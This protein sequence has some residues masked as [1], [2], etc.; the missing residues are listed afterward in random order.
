[1]Q[2][3]K[4]IQKFSITNKVN[5]NF[6]N[7]FLYHS[8]GNLFYSKSLNLGIKK[9]LLF[10]CIICAAS[11]NVFS[12]NILNQPIDKDYSGYSFKQCFNELEGKY[13]IIFFYKS[14][15]I[16]KNEIPKIPKNTTLKTF[17][18]TAL[19]KYQL[20]YIQIQGSNIV[21][22]PNA[23]SSNEYANTESLIKQIGNPIDKGKYELN[24]VEGYVYFGKTSEPITGALIVDK[25]HN[26]QTITDY[27]GY[28][29][30][31]LPGGPTELQFSFIGLEKQVI[32]IDVFSHGKL[33]C[34]LMETPIA[35]GM[36]NIF[37]NSAKR[38][39]EQTQMGMAHVE[40]K[41]ISKLP[42]LMGETDIVKSMTL[43]PGIQSSGDLAA[44]FNVRGGNADQNLV[45]INGAT[46]FNTSHLFGM[47][48]TLIPNSINSVSMFK[49]TQTA[50]YGG[51]LSSVMDIGLTKPDTAKIEGKAGIGI[52][53][54]SLFVEGPIK[55]NFC[56]FMVG[57][58][59]T[60]SNWLL[61]TI[62]DIEIRNSQASFYDL[63]GKLDFKLNR[64]NRL[65]LFGYYSHDNFN[66]AQKNSYAYGTLIG[67]LNYRLYANSVLSIGVD[68]SHTDYKNSLG[69]IKDTK[70]AYMVSTGIAQTKLKIEFNLHLNKNSFV[71]GTDAGLYDINPGVKQ[72]YTDESLIIPDKVDN[73]KAI[74]SAAFAQDNITIT[75]KISLLLGLRY[76]WYSKYGSSQA[77]IYDPNSS[78]SDNSVTDTIN[79]GATELVN[80]YSGFEP[81]IGIKVKI[82]D[83]S[84]IKSGYHISRQYQH[85]IS[86]TSSPTPS[87][88]WKSTD[89]NIKPMVSHQLSL[90][91][92]RNFFEN[93]IETSAEAYYKTIS[94]TVDYRNGAVLVMNPNIERDVIAGFTQ[95]Y[96]LELM[97]KKNLGK[98]NGWLSYTI[99]R[100]QTKIDGRFP[101]D[102]INRGNYFPTYSDRLHDISLSVNYQFTRRWNFAG[103]FIFSS[104]RPTTYPE[105]KY[106]YR[107]VEVVY[108]SDRNKYRLPA[109]H[110]LDVSVTYEG[111]LKKTNKVHP[112]FTFSVY[113][114][115]GHK[116]TYSVY[117]K[118]DVPSSLNNYQK[119]GLYKLSIIGVPIPSVTVNLSF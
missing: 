52:L 96:G 13:S 88:Y 10:I 86:N 23:Y 87:D 111:F 75:N 57:G 59:T 41:S 46:L 28:Y 7:S 119:Y 103:N 54:S 106:E 49:G 81:R 17:I 67:G 80:P 38:N 94:N 6:M 44:G 22:I 85:L 91:Y 9:K 62:N 84:S 70:Q 115:Y 95:A 72:K 19:S 105:K 60:Y 112:S 43:L 104:G 117:Y 61:N 1:M 116:N 108:Y 12:Q 100:S 15:W 63:I 37:A 36:V 50:N 113:N 47:F 32:K 66:Y 93:I 27:K 25:K 107:N 40:M 33:N 83:Y 73:E 89:I 4:K 21:I 97:I 5:S 20:S 118:A 109:Y 90:G 78:I 3:K 101:E 71:F 30:L 102:K 29:W 2:H 58:R 39:I 55:N 64:K 42:V 51:K 48:S 45:L 16:E 11:I 69:Y 99:S 77:Y 74:E 82:N 8:I 34:E 26:K 114:L 14:S 24:R 92:F 56:S 53:N 35:I 31:D 98:L 68:L 79:F 65:S 76:S 110:R 18:E